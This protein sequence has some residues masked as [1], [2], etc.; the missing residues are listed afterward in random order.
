MSSNKKP[1]PERHQYCGNALSPS[2]KLGTAS[3]SVT[4]AQS[5]L[6]NVKEVSI[7]TSM[8]RSSIYNMRRTKTFPQP[9]RTGAR[10][11]RFVRAD[12]EAWIGQRPSVRTTKSEVV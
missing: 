2:H 10:A 8:S 9:V 3:S 4:K 6:L 5:V 12:V 1:E 7:L 11:V